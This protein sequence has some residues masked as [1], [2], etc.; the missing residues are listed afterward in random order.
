MTNILDFEKGVPA[1]GTSQILRER[2]V[3]VGI[4]FGNQYGFWVFASVPSV[5]RVPGVGTCSSACSDRAPSTPVTVKS[6]RAKTP[7]CMLSLL[8][9]Y[10]KIATWSISLRPFDFD[11]FRD[12][13]WVRRNQLATEK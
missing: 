6:T 5:S 10:E 9:L 13:S 2:S 12:A 8:N 7:Y 1:R 3:G 11:F 4:S